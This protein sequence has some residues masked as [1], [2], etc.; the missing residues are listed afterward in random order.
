ML[1]QS[2]KERM[3]HLWYNA[4]SLIKMKTVRHVRLSVLLHS[5]LIWYPFARLAQQQKFG[6]ELK[7]KELLV[8]LKAK[9]KGAYLCGY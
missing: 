5:D 3:C 1:C 4:F 9:R 2:V 8:V 6:K 7:K